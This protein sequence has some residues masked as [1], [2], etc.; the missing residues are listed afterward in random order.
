[1][2]VKKNPDYKAS[3]SMPI[4]ISTF[5]LPYYRDGIHEST[6]SLRFL[7]IIWRFLRLEVS[8]FVFSYSVGY[9]SAVPPLDVFL[10][11]VSVGKRC[12]DIKIK[13]KKIKNNATFKGKQRDN[14]KPSP[15][16]LPPALHPSA[17]PV[18]IQENLDGV[19]SADGGDCE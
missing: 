17:V 7:G 12:I 13:R 2:T 3:L 4:C 8:A 16:P 6:I 1:M 15:P 19:K 9:L 10:I 18:E 5:Y 14:A 11:V